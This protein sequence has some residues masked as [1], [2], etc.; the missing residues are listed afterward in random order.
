MTTNWYGFNNNRNGKKHTPSNKKN[1]TP[2]ENIGLVHCCTSAHIK[3][4]RVY[5]HQSSDLFH[6]TEWNR[7]EKKHNLMWIFVTKRVGEWWSN[8]KWEFFVF[9]CKRYQT[10][11]DF[12]KQQPNY[13]Q[14]FFGIS[15]GL[16]DNNE[17]NISAS[18][19]RALHPLCSLVGVVGVP[20]V[21]KIMGAR[22]DEFQFVIPN[23]RLTTTIMRRE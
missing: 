11:L 18:V 16:T 6:L 15:I 8:F 7:E 17:N 9:S 21:G 20:V 4:T 1:P 3:I 5:I 10:H 22:R 19:M 14:G 13:Q 12:H 2:W 23:P